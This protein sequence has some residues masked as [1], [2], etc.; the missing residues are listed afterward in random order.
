MP[1]RRSEK[2]GKNYMLM[3]KEKEIERSIERLKGYVPDTG[4]RNAII[5]SV[6][7]ATYIE[8]GSAYPGILS[9]IF[10]WA[11]YPLLRKALVTLSF[12][13]V[14][15]FTGQQILIINRIDKLE[16]RVVE[17][18]TLQLLEHQGRNVLIKSAIKTSADDKDNI[19]SIMVAN[20]DLRSLVE[21]YNRLQ[22]QYADLENLYRDQVK[23]KL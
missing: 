18:T 17:S 20:K 21:S 22:K 23:S 13:L 15:V 3:N 1:G 11:E 12:L 5:D 7:S 19:D 6:M 10:R 9:Y 4:R 2:T 8:K 14:L 16:G